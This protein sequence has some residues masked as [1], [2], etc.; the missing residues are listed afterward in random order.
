M[1]GIDLGG[2]FAIL[3]RYPIQLLRGSLTHSLSLSLSLSLIFLSLSI[4]ILDY[5]LVFSCSRHN[6]F[7]SS[8]FFSFS[9]LSLFFS[10]LFPFWL[11]PFVCYPTAT[12]TLLLPYTNYSSVLFLPLSLSLSFFHYSST[13][14]TLRSL[15]RCFLSSDHETMLALQITRRELVLI[16]SVFDLVQTP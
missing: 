4:I 16:L 12:T 6:C 11:F 5:L 8:F 10:F 15:L 7:I 13:T 2:N 9:L 14:T 3:A 1:Y